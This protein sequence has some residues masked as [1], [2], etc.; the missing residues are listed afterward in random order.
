MWELIVS[1]NLVS[2]FLHLFFVEQTF[3]LIFALS[4]KQSMVATTASVTLPL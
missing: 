1:C 3:F 4:Y 2:I